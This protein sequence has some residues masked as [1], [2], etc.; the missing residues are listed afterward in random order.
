MGFMLRG[1]GMVDRRDFLRGG[2]GA[3]MAAAV[4]GRTRAAA[5]HRRPN[6]IVVLCDDLGFGDISAYGARNITT[7]AID[8][9]AR[10]GVLLSNFYSAA[11]LCT[12]SRAGLLTGRY[13]IRSG[14][15][16]E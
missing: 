1:L 7:P 11:N 2:A 9:M 6:F 5:T 14:L 15:A 4:T 12:P 3:L 16:Y 8:K 13:A 10:E